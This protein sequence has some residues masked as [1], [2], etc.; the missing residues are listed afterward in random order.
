MKCG[1]PRRSTR[2]R[3]Q[4]LGWKWGKKPVEDHLTWGQKK[5][6]N[7]TLMGRRA[8]KKPSGTKTYFHESSTTISGQIEFV[9]GKNSVKDS[10]NSLWLLCL[11]LMSTWTI[12]TIVSWITTRIP[13]SG[14]VDIELESHL[15]Q[16]RS[17]LLKVLWPPE[18][19]SGTYVVLYDSSTSLKL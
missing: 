19:S 17:E 10:I 8:R 1:I 12:S 9:L 16:M 11:H 4:I 3:I 14:Q 5:S 18:R 15:R 2:P 13:W 6:C 7:N